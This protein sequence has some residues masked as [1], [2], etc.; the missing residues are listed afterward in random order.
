MTFNLIFVTCES[1]TDN[2]VGVTHDLFGYTCIRCFKYFFMFYCN[3]C[4]SPVFIALICS[5]S[6]G[7]G[8]GGM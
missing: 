7:E 6:T 8:G 1:H 4:T 3:L 2:A 5:A